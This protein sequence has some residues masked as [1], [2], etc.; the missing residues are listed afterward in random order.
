MKSSKLIYTSRLICRVV[1]CVLVV[2]SSLSQ[3]R[4]IKICVRIG[5]RL[6]FIALCLKHYCDFTSSVSAIRP[7]LLPFSAKTNI[8]AWS[9]GLFTRCIICIQVFTCNKKELMQISSAI[10][11]CKNNEKMMCQKLF[12]HKKMTLCLAKPIVYVYRFFFGFF[13]ER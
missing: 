8:Q 13:F 4:C 6:V 2:V 5:A 11:K 3:Y 12:N 9:L 1:S 10:T 7:Y